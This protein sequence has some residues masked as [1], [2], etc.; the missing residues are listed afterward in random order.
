[1]EGMLTFTGIII[2]VFG[3]LQIILF[4]KIWGMTNDIS[5]MKS[6]ISDYITKKTQVLTENKADTILERDIKVGD[7]VVELKNE[8]QLKVVNITDNGEFECTVPG[9]ISSIG[10]FNRS[11]IEVFNKYWKKSK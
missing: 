6:I 5:D 7:L 11:E 1:M 2:I 10:L 9:G 3:I 4:F 8:R